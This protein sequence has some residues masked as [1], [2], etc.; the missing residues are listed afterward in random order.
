MKYLKLLMV[1]R[2]VSTV[3]QE[4]KGANRPWYLSRRFIGI[5]ITFLGLCLTVFTGYEASEIHL[6]I[7]S[8]NIAAIVSAAISLYGIVMGIVGVVCKKKTEL[9]GSSEN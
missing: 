5:V 3:Y 8:D 9:S 4:E 1:L 6:S 2:D 7:M